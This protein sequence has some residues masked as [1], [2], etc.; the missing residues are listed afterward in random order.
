MANDLKLSILLTNLGWADIYK[1]LIILVIFVFLGAKQYF[2]KVRQWFS[3]LKSLLCLLYI[4][5]Y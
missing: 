3:L 4:L 5:A 1:G 2:L